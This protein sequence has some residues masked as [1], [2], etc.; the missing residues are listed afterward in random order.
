MLKKCSKSVNILLYVSNALQTSIGR[1]SPV[2]DIE[3]SSD[4]SSE[5]DQ[6]DTEEGGGKQ[7]DT[8]SH[9]T[10]RNE[11]NGKTDDTEEGAVEDEAASSSSSD[12]VSNNCISQHFLQRDEGH[13]CYLCREIHHLTSTNLA[14]FATEAQCT[15]VYC[16]IRLS[17]RKRVSD[18]GNL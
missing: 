6:V 14:T 4:S 11:K 12:G 5:D 10:P 18:N 15:H 8:E 17:S 3:E 9:S 7:I 13:F 1:Q 2:I 16:F